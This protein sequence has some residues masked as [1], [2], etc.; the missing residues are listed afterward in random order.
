MFPFQPPQQ[1]PKQAAL[2]QMIRTFG[3]VPPMVEPLLL[4]VL[5]EDAEI[6]AVARQFVE[7]KGPVYDTFIQAC[8]EILA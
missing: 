6:E 8:R 1:T 2:L 4:S 7:A 5:P 3:S